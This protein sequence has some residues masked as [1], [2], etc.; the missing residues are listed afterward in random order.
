LKAEKPE[1]SG[2]GEVLKHGDFP[3]A[4][5]ADEALLDGN[6]RLKIPFAQT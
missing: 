3:E 1:V 5:F 2:S 4:I 6:F